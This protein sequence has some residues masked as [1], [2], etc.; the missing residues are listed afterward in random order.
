[1]VLASNRPAGRDGEALPGAKRLFLP[2]HTGRGVVGVIGLDSDRPGAAAQRRSAPA[3]RCALRPGG[4]CHRADQSRPRRRPGAAGGGDR[5]AA[6]GAADLD[7]ARSAHAARLDPRLGDEPEDPARGARR[8]RQRETDQHH[9]GR[10]R[11][12]QPLHRQ[13]ARHDAAGIRRDRA[14]RRAGRSVATSSAARWSGPA[15][16]WQRIRSQVGLPPDLPMLQ[17]DP[18][19][20]EQVL[21]NL[22]DNAAQIRAGRHRRSACRRGSEGEHRPSPGPRRGRGHP[23]RRSRAHLRQVLSRPCRRP[24]ACGHRASASPSAAASSRPWAARSP[25]ATVRT[26]PARSSP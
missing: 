20:F 1:M 13:S 11:A 14:A 5:A 18:V 7:L 21:F 4:A 12:A 8:K 17:L 15:R 23:G 16:S 6:L 22:L 3:A 19:L 10:G 26:R 25:P 9:P 2:M 24:A